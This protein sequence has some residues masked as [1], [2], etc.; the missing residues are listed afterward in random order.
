MISM[1]RMA[2]QQERGDAANG[3]VSGAGI[4]VMDN[5]VGMPREIYEE[6]VQTALAKNE[7]SPLVEYALLKLSMLDIKEE[8]YG[9]GLNRLKAMLEEYPNTRL[10]KEVNQ[11]YEAALVHILTNDFKV[12]KYKRIVNT[13]QAEKENLVR[14]TSPEPF[15]V[16]AR[17]AS[18][19]N[20]DDL[21]GEMYKM[22]DPY[23]ADQEKPFDLL[24]HLADDQLQ[25]GN[26][27]AALVYA[28]VLIKNNPSGRHLVDGCVLKGTILSGLGSHKRAAA[29]FSTALDSIEDPCDRPDILIQ[30]VKALSASGLNAESYQTLREADGVLKACE[31]VDQTILAEVGELYLKAG[32]PERAL[33]II[34]AVRQA[35]SPDAE[36]P[37]LQLVMARCYERLDSKDAYV[38]IYSR[39]AGQDDQFYGKVAREKMDEISFNA[40]IQKEM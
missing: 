20:L 24:F 9:R 36:E 23:L 27:Q 25:S 1:Y 19:L 13:Y 18:A 16:M 21:A 29:M 12:K 3:R 33:E 26:P 40:V 35:D 37:R 4:M 39:V 10:K 32:Q 8:Q 28:D 22:A 31:R 6:V 11:A 15:L 38:S 30:K 5:R 14:F 17:A 2:E 34:Q 7:T